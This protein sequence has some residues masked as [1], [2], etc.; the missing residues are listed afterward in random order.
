[1]R[2]TGLVL[3]ITAMALVLASGVAMAV[4]LT[5]GAG[6]DPISGLARWR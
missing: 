2:K 1:M 6:D 3:I 4:T 5:G